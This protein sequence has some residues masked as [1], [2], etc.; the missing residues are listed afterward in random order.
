MFMINK[1]I[2]VSLLFVFMVVSAFSYV[3]TWRV[4]RNIDDMMRMIDFSGVFA[5]ER[6]LVR[7]TD[8][9]LHI[10]RDPISDGEYRYA[11]W[12]KSSNGESSMNKMKV[13]IGSGGFQEIRENFTY[14]HAIELETPKKWGFFH[15]NDPIYVKSMRVEYTTLKGER[16]V[17]RIAVERWFNKKDKRVFPL[18][19]IAKD[20]Q[21]IV[22]AACKDG[23]KDSCAL[24]VNSHR[25]ELEDSFSNPYYS[26]VRDFKEFK[27]DLNFMDKDEAMRRL[28]EIG[29]KFGVSY[30]YVDTELINRLERVVREI[31]NNT[32]FALNSLRDISFSLQSEN[33]D[34]TIM[35]GIDR[36]IQLLERNQYGDA[37]EA[38]KILNRVIDQLKSDY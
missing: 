7:L 29:Q 4:E 27:D 6:E 26:E 18:E 9:C 35:R 3:D 34:H 5:N 19:E 11:E 32:S 36:A 30:N 10:L 38:A 20:A 23:E 17:K 24:Y 22:L 25:A 14:L 8:E 31:D 15:G 21:V 13:E 37:R 33:Y 16:K 1:K 2:V 28:H 12:R